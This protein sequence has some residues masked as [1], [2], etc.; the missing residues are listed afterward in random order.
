MA[1]LAAGR[2]ALAAGWARTDRP[3]RS[4]T[5]CRRATPLADSPLTPI[6][7][8]ICCIVDGTAEPVRAASCR[9]SEVGMVTRDGVT[10]GSLLRAARADVGRDST[11]RTS[12]AGVTP[13]MVVVEKDTEY[14]T[15]PSSLLPR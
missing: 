13:P 4:A 2:R 12:S 6:E 3:A 7:T 8:R 1:C 14:D 9:R 5:C 11:L 15:E 10:D